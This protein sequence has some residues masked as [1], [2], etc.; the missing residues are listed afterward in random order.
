[1]RVYRTMR[2]LETLY[3]VN[4]N[5]KWPAFPPFIPFNDNVS[6]ADTHYVSLRILLG[7]NGTRYLDFREPLL[8]DKPDGNAAEAPDAVLFEG[9]RVDLAA[10]ILFN[11]TDARNS[12]ARY[13]LMDS[14]CRNMGNRL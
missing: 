8:T 11:G 6:R 1:M 4:G 2:N 5:S 10:A 13:Y 14:D 12:E 9:S 3:P 7:T